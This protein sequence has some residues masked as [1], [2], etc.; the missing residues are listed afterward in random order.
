MMRT[1]FDWLL[2]AER[3]QEPRDPGVKVEERQAW[4]VKDS[5]FMERVDPQDRD[6]FLNICPERKYQPGE[7]I[8]HEGDP[9][10]PCTS[11]PW[12]R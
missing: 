10:A 5:G 3:G 11:S 1:R 7:T 2:V 12:A 6:V 4:Y 9:L 8:F